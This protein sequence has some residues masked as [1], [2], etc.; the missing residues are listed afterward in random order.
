MMAD[1]PDFVEMMADFWL[2]F[3]C[4]VLE[5]TLRRLRVDAIQL[6]EDMA[7]KAHSMISPAMVRRFLM[8]CYRAWHALAETY[9]CPI[10]DMDSDG[11]VSEL[12]P[13]WVES[14]INVCD[15]MEVAAGNDIVAERQRWGARNGFQGRA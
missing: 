6:S 3:T 13:L 14:G 11:Q 15:P 4:Q 12:I 8:P 7:Y 10:L 1:Q 9:G 5:E 2:R